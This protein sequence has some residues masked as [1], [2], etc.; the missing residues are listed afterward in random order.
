MGQRQCAL[1]SLGLMATSAAKLPSPGF[2]R[3]KRVLLTG[4]TGFKGAWT[5]LWLGEM[6]AEITGFSLPPDSQPALFD[7][8]NVGSGI[9]SR[10]GDLRDPEQVRHAVEAAAPEIVLHMA[11]QPIVRRAIAE[12]VDTLASNIMGTAHLLDALRA[13]SS[14]KAILVVTSDKV[15]ANQETGHPFTEADRLGGKDP[16]SASKAG[17]ELV[18]ASFAAT[19]FTPRNIPLGT[20]RGGNVIGGG[21]YAADRIVPDIYRAVAGDERLV[22]RMPGAT[23]PWQHVLDCVAGYLMFAEALRSG[24]EVPRALNFGP[25]P[26]GDAT[27]GGL[28]A[29]MLTAMGK[30]AH[31]DYQPVEGNVEMKALAVESSL[32]RNVLGWSDLLAGEK[33]VNWTADWYRQVIAGQN[34]RDV[35]MAQIRAYAALT[36]NE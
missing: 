32:A 12:P 16:Y 13:C 5:A 24:A 29:A 11:A 26:G 28:A 18:T 6:G 1:E 20:A 21:D 9:A 36:G 33:I 22:L 2:W 34:A 35:T 7:L 15:Y 4:H 19:Y 10:L 31:W 27:V 23:R 17:T 3:D 25:L 14:V 8:A 30:P